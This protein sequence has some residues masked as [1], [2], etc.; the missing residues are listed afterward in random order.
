[1]AAKQQPPE[2]HFTVSLPVDLY[3]RV[4]EMAFRRET[5]IKEIITSALEKHILQSAKDDR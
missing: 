1:M 4:R 5:T 2:K 3:K